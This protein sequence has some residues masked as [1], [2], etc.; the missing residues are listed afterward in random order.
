MPD[1]RRQRDAARTERDQ[2]RREVEAWRTV[3]GE[4]DPA[5]LTAYADLCDLAINGLRRPDDLG[6]PLSMGHPTS[7]PPRYHPAAYHYRNEERRIQR[8]RATRLRSIVEALTEDGVTSVPTRRSNTTSTPL[9]Q[10][11]RNTVTST[12]VC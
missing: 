12:P 7:S 8:D 6:G 1:F 11:S 5:Y 2:L 10:P 9:A 3:Y 4:I